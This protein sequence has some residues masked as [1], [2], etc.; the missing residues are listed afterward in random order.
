[1]PTGTHQKYEYIVRGSFTDPSG[2]VLTKDISGIY[3]SCSTAKTV[4]FTDTTTGATITIISDTND[5][6]EIGDY[7]NIQIDIQYDEKEVDSTNA[8]YSNK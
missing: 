6:Y 1:M 3:Y 8:C 2:N 5:V 7:M 4:T